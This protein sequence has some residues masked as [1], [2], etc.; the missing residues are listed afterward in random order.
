MSFKYNLLHYNN[1]TAK[2]CMHLLLIFNP[3]LPIQITK[4]R[5]QLIKLTVKTDQ[6]R[7]SA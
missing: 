1:Y 5:G 7:H 6:I 3:P 2:D 4:Q